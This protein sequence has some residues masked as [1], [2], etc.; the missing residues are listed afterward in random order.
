MVAFAL[1]AEGWWLRSAITWIKG[2]AMPESVRDRPTSAT[3]MVFL[4]TKSP[5]YFYDA[6]ATRLLGHHLNR[7]DADDEAGLGAGANLRNWWYINP[8]PFTGGAHF[9]VF[10]TRLVE[11]CVLAGCP[12]R[13]CPAC[14]APW[15]RRTERERIAP[16]PA[17]GW[18]EAGARGDHGRSA[19]DLHGRVVTRDLGWAPGCAHGLEPIGGV[20]LDPFVGSGT[21]VMV[22]LRHGRRGIG[23][24]LSP[25]YAEM[26][27][28]R[29]VGD[30]P[31]WNSEDG[32]PVVAEAEPVADKQAAVG[33]RTYVGFNARWKAEQAAL[34]PEAGG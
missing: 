28:N 18:R 12:L 3:E 29:I 20:V 13:V 31:M 32:A 22:A 11:P 7:L 16:A 5:T 21:T 30:C 27:R 1:R 2:S 10:P 14:G 26:A 8:Q 9:A 6:A 15:V 25:A 24:E 4:L 33:K 23:I 17:S 19:G 34:L